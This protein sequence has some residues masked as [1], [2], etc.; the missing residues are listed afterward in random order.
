MSCGIGRLSSPSLKNPAYAG[1]FV[2][3]RTR[4]VKSNPDKRTVQKPLPESEW[5]IHIRDVY[6]HYIDWTTYEKIQVMIR[7]NRSEYDRNRTRGIPRPGKALLH[8]VVYC[9][10]CGHKMVVQYKG[11]T[12]YL[13]TVRPN[14]TVRAGAAPGL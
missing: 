9:G 6:P 1:S 12:Q 5:R 3:G 2:Y 13:V 4:T 7:D 10:E 8:G 14:H 11:D